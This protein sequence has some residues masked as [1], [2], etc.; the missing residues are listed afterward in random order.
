MSSQRSEPPAPRFYRD[1]ASWRPI[2]SPP[3]E[4]ADEADTYLRLL[5]EAS[6]GSLRS[7]LELGSGGGND[8]SHLKAHL[9]LTLVDRS[10][11]MLELS[12]PL[13][14]ECRHLLGD[15]RT[16]RIGSTFD[17]V[18]LHDAF[19]YLTTDIDDAFV[20]LATRAD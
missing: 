4:Y 5:R 7:V 15:M 16:V 1:F 13:N 12:R 2:L 18:F 6:D 20:F 17:A 3:E 10:P 19:A 8:A 14:P 11:G 9:E